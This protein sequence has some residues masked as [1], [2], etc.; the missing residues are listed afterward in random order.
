MPCQGP[1]S[2]WAAWEDMTTSSTIQGVP[3]VELEGQCTKEKSSPTEGVWE[4]EAGRTQR[5]RPGP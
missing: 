5:L 1:S 4:P 3:G 2:H